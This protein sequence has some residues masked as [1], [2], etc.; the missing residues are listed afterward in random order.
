MP[1]SKKISKSTLR[2]KFKNKEDFAKADVLWMGKH[3]WH[4]VDEKPPKKSFIESVLKSRSEKTTPTSIEELF[5]KHK[6]G[7]KCL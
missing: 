7:S 6:K 5:G 2:A 3:G 4:P 1:K